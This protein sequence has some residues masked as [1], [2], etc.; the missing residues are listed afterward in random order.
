MGFNT[1]I[2]DD[3]NISAY[4]KLVYFALSKYVGKEG[5]CWPSQKTL[6]HITGLSRNTVSRSLKELEISKRVITEHRFV[7]GMKTSSLYLLPDLIKSDISDMSNDNPDKDILKCSTQTENIATL[8]I[9]IMNNDVPHRGLRCSPQGD[10][11]IHINLSNINNDE[12]KI[13]D[14]L[15]TISQYPFDVKKDLEQV[16]EWLKKYSAKHILNELENFNSWWRDKESSFKKKKNFRS[17]ITNWLKRSQQQT[18]ATK[19]KRKFLFDD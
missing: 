9:P 7:N 16:R 12:Q 2:L 14:Y 19:P 11:L 10:K 17:S 5:K 8:D 4:G 6:Q 15:P 18:Q 13:L 1:D 3:E